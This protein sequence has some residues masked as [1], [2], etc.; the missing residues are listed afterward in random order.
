LSYDD[1]AQAISR[2]EI[3][4]AQFLYENSGIA[5]RAISWSA[6]AFGLAL[7][8]IAGLGPS[9]R[10]M[11]EKTILMEQLATRLAPI[12][13][14][15]PGML[16]EIANLLHWPDYDCHHMRC[17]THL[18]QRNAAARANLNAVLAKHSVPAIHAATK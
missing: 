14:I 2:A 9:S 4:R 12:E 13:K 3:A 11:L 16:D 7:A 10:Q 15:T 8:T 17:D 5:L 1:L 18:E 6:L